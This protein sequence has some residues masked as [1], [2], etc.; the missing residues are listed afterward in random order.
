[1]DAFEKGAGYFQDVYFDFY[2]VLKQVISIVLSDFGFVS[3]FI[4]NKLFSVFFV[5]MCQK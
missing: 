5:E 1:M 4:S 2:F 3:M